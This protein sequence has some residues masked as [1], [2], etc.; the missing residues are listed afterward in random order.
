[1][2]GKLLNLT[3]NVFPHFHIT[4]SFSLKFLKFE[5]T[6]IFLIIQDL[7]MSL[8]CAAN[9]LVGQNEGRIEGDDWLTICDK[10]IFNLFVPRGALAER[11]LISE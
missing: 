5:T 1:M 11:N 10:T 7:E 6:E 2:K 8:S 3:R 4:S 9:Q